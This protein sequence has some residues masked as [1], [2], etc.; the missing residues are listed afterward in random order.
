M[1]VESKISHIAR[2][3]LI[4]SAQILFS[5]GELVSW[6][7]EEPRKVCPP[8]GLG[9]QKQLTSNF[10]P[11]I[12]VVPE[13]FR[14]LFKEHAILSWDSWYITHLTRGPHDISCKMRDLSRNRYMMHHKS[15]IVCSNPQMRFFTRVLPATSEKLLLIAKPRLIDWLHDLPP[16]V[17]VDD[18]PFAFYWR[19]WMTLNHGRPREVRNFEN[20]ATTPSRLWNGD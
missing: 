20:D 1:V 15:R 5:L 8:E 12:V 18:I 14:T 4:Y 7:L 17:W 2:T 16:C 6:R 13:H 3:I 11:H 10:K 19:R 9:A